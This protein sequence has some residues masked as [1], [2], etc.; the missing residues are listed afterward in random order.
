MAMTITA[1]FDCVK[2]SKA[3]AD[4]KVIFQNEEDRLRAMVYVAMLAARNYEGMSRTVFDLFRV[5]VPGKSLK[6]RRT[7]LVM[8]IGPGDTGEPVITISLPGES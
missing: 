8:Q 2:W 3:T 5:P 1:W 6:P 7:S 4:R